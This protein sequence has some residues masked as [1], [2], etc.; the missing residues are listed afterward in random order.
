MLTARALFMGGAIV[1]AAALVGCQT[2]K[3]EMNWNRM[4]LGMTHDEVAGAL[5]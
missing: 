1:A 5:G 3:Y 2:P 4:R